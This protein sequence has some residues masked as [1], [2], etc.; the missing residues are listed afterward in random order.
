MIL[1]GCHEESLRWWKYSSILTIKIL[2]VILYYIFA[3]CFHWGKVVEG[4]IVFLFHTTACKPVVITKC[5]VFYFFKF[6]STKW[7]IQLESYHY[8]NITEYTDNDM[9]INSS[10]NAKKKRKEKKHEVLQVFYRADNHHLSSCKRDH[11]WV[12]SSLCKQLLLY[13]RKR[14][15]RT[16][17]KCTAVTHTAKFSLWKILKVK[18]SRFLPRWVV[19]K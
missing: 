7:L 1:K 16:P 3:R 5:I 8:S 19:R 11:L 17:P 14:Q 13:Q 18:Y 6:P 2:V 9:K 4:Y 10:Q 15:Q 12:S